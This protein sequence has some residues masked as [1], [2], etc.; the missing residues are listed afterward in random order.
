MFGR[1]GVRERER[2]LV[3]VIHNEE[4]HVTY[5][6]PYIVRAIKSRMRWAEHVAQMGT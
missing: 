2:E 5:F 3:K 4:L 1:E 6:S